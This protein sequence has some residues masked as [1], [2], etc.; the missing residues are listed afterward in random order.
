MKM[1]KTI[2]FCATLLAALWC[3]VPQPVQAV[4]KIRKVEVVNADGNE[5][6]GKDDPLKV[7]DTIRITFRLVNLGWGTSYTNTT[8]VNPWSFAYTGPS[9]AD[10]P[11]MN[12][13]IVANWQK[14]PCLG[15]WM[16]GSGL[17][18]EAKLVKDGSVFDPPYW[19]ADKIPNSDGEEKHYTDVVFEYTIQGGDLGL[20]IQLARAD[21]KGP[22]G[23]GD[24]YYLKCDGQTVPWTLK[25]S[26]RTRTADFTFGPALLNEDPDFSGS[27][28]APE[29][30]TSWYDYVQGRGYEA[31]DVDLTKAGVYA[32]AI[33]FDSTF[34][35]ST[36]GIWRSIAQGA[37]TPDPSGLTIEIAGARG[38]V[39]PMELYVWTD[40]TN[41]AEVVKGGRII[42]D[43]VPMVFEHE[44]TSV[45]RTVGKIEIYANDTSV[46]FSIKATGETNTTTKVFLSATPTNIYNASGGLITNFI[47]RTI[48]VGEPLP[49]GITVTVNGKAKETVT[50]VAED[51]TDPLRVNVTLSEPWTGSAPL[52][53]PIKVTVKGHPDLNAGDYVGLSDSSETGNTS[54][55]DTLSVDVGKTS[56]TLSL[57][58]FPNRGTSAT[59]NDGLLVTVTGIEKS[60]VGEA[61]ARIR[62]FYPAEP[63]KGKGIKYEGEHIRRK[64]GK[65]VA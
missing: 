57:W 19:L 30:L 32:Q 63:Y 48:L 38:A 27:P 28:G 31:I 36:A 54:W 62:S 60:H 6:G 1:N 4:G 49:P 37:T 8:Y 59:E 15:L 16:G 10:D 65:K 34:F 11:V 42:T 12:E 50:A 45:T 21:G 58:M 18:R 23:A 20:P 46:P 2:G 39:K 22:V 13:Q 5:R 25:D 24:S 14:M 7:G 40:S 35:N 47:T 43:P 61:A 29:D 56:A 3:A 51:Q 17:V 26:T 64:Q 53:V 33:D 9:L 41:V 52:T 55:F 44:G